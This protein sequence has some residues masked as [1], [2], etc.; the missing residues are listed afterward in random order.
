M[1]SQEN[2][3][4]IAEE[5]ENRR[6]SAIN[7]A[8]RRA[9]ELSL[10]SEDA[11]N[12]ERDLRST[13][14]SLFRAACRGEDITPIREKNAALLRRKAEILKSLGLPEDYTEPNYVC[15]I[16]SDTGYKGSKMC[17][18]FKEMLITENIKSSGM[19]RLIEKQSFDNFRLDYYEG[20]SSVYQRMKSNLDAARGFAESFGKSG[21]NLLLIGKTGTGK[22][23]ISTSIARRAIE[24]GF[25]VLYDSAQN[26][27]SAFE[28]DRFKSGY[29]P[30]EA[31]GD[32]YLEC[33]LL[34]LD[35][36][37][38]EYVNQFTVSCLYNLLNTRYNKGLS[39]VISTNLSPEELLSKY[40][41]RIY[42][43]IVGCDTKILA[44]LGE[45]RR[46]GGL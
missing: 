37:G 26:I 33:D 6:R 16:C 8:D 40:D 2:Y 23:H 20:D 24:R 29:G 28:N 17:S 44:F 36:L 43:R 31:K 9:L 38:T 1:Y 39:T 14:L 11:K 46:L 35:D 25:E 19:G 3:R 7:E 22:T 4:K 15:K 10:R 12:T 41:D 27:V 30:Y 21:E 5:I 34:I 13:G 42:S 18:C 32:K 45:D